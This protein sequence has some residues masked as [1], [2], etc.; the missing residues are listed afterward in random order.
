MK[1]FVDYCGCCGRGFTQGTDLWCMDCLQAH[2]DTNA[3]SPE[4]ATWFA[5]HGTSC[6]FADDDGTP[7]QDPRVPVTGSEK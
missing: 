4:N 6:P 2:V 5:Q 7:V 3:H 1:R